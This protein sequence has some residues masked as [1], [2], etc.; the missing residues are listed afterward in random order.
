M[1]K[2]FLSIINISTRHTS[3]SKNL[4]GNK[5]HNGING[6]ARSGDITND[7]SNHLA[8]FLITSYQLHSETKPKKKILTRT[9]KSFVHNNFKHNL[10]NFDWEYTLDIH[11]HDT[12]HSLEQF[13]KK[14]ND[15][16]V[17]HAPLLYIN[18]TKKNISKAWITK[19]ILK[20]IKIKN[21]LSN[22]FCRAKD[23]KSKSDL[24]KKF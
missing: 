14:V 1:F 20:S 18:K 21:T 5:L 9:F 10:Q 6:S 16:L 24:H 8:Q 19:G 4:I 22:T 12:N 3:R 17:K 7:I 15:I 13:L 11:F 2:Q 23:N